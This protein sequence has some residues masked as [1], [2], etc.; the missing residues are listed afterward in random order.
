MKSL[1]RFFATSLLLCLSCTVKAA[2][3]SVHY[4]LSFTNA[5]H[6]EAEITVT[7]SGAE[8]EYLDFRMSRSSPG[9]YA[10]H[11]FAKNVYNVTATDH[12]GEV[13]PVERVS[14]YAWQVKNDPKGTK[15]TYTLFA[16]HADGT[17]SGIDQTHAH[18]NM[19]ATLMWSEA[20]TT[21]PVS[22]SF[23][24]YSKSWNVATQLVKTSTPYDF[25]A[26]DLQYLMDS[27]TELSKQDVISWTQESGGKQYKINLAVHHPGLSE[28]V[29]L[30]AEQ[31]KKV[32]ATQMVVFGELADFDYGEYTFI[33]CYMPQNDGDG[34][35]HRNST[36]LIESLP[37]HETELVHFGHVATL[38]HEF[39]HSWN[40]ERIRPADLEPFD[41]TRANPTRNLWFAEGFTSYYGELTLKRTGEYDDESYYSTLSRTINAVMHSNGPGHFSPEGMSMQAPFRD[42]A[43][44]IDQ[45]NFSNIFLSYYT[46]GHGL[47]IALDLMIRS[48]FP[49][50]SLDDMMQLAWQKLGKA[51]KPYEVEDLQTILAETV[52]DKE[53]AAEFFNRYIHGQEIPPYKELLANAGLSLELESPDTA[54]LGPV[55]IDFKDSAAVITGNTKK[56]SPL[57]LAGLDKGDAIVQIGRYRI[58]DEARWDLA[59]GNF[60]PGDS[61]TLR[62]R[63]FDKEY[64]VQVTFKQRADLSINETEAA[65]EE[66]SHA[67]RDD[68]LGAN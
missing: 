41:F 36:Y 21:A 40:V 44:Y 5:A 38:S 64:E 15:V 55:Y 37:I 9:R 67:F 47:A 11:E 43:I 59:M 50:K 17:Y 34:M 42:A 39:F 2:E 30:L 3:P 48:E 28:D 31:A 65:E 27:P 53:F 12:T 46:Y 49:G 45:T 20:L 51:G 32:V 57:Y 25:T 16:N 7:F 61:S 58:S 63:R 19:P 68:W 23:I 8:G 14:P 60:K 54:T 4:S 56:D 13:L 18:L 26:P 52:D 35:E 62:Y 22:V 29:E 10:I 24:P 33:A 6:H 66:S 1:F